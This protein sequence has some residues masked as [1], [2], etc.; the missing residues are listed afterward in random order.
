M[1][2]GPGHASWAH[3][4]FSIFQFP[5]LPK[6]EPPGIPPGGDAARPFSRWQWSS[7]RAS[8]LF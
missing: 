6:K 7:Q 5:G 8:D 2:N 3:F 4:P 1:E